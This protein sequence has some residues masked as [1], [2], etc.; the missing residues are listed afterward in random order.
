MLGQHT[1]TVLQAAPID[2]WASGDWHS[3][4]F[5]PVPGLIG[6]GL[7]AV[8]VV[9]VLVLSF[10]VAGDSSI[11]APT[12]LGMLLAALALPLLPGM[13][14]S[15]LQAIVIIGMTVAVWRIIRQWVVA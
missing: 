4:L 6:E 11:A 14:A 15:W 7:F 5:D 10:Y 12:V 13:Y 1:A 2:D 3:A 9:G 8:F